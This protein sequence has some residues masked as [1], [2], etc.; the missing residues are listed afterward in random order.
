MDLLMEKQKKNMFK[1]MLR[2][3]VVSILI[4]ILAAGCASAASSGS[5]AT[6]PVSTA[7]PLTGSSTESTSSATV[8]A[9]S[10]PSP[11]A[12]STHNTASP[13]LSSGGSP[14]S[15]GASS[16]EIQYMVVS[17]KSEARYRV[18]EQ[19]ANVSLPSDAIGKTSQISGSVL[20]KPDGSIDSS[21]SKITVDLSS[22]QSDR[23][24]R[25]NFLRQ[26][27]LQ[28]NQYPKAVFIPMT[29]SGLPSPLPQSGQ[30]KFQ[31]TGNLTIR[32]VT[33]PVTWDVTGSVQGNQATGTATTTFKFEDFNLTQP[34]VPIVLSVVDHITLE[35][36]ITLQ[37]AGQ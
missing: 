31:L 14:T 22:L 13:T 19:L 29:V 2:I 28:T 5:N 11:A 35:V 23:G 8:A 16:G 4:L 12:A 9:N 6:P 10:T 1:K 37:R 24:G 36:D 32:D 26:N 7:L 20:V 15:P 27:V 18:R 34:K 21:N 33:K 30:V 25:D 17:D 3:Q